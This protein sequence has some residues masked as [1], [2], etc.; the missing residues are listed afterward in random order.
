ML[1]AAGLAAG[2]SSMGNHSDASTAMTLDQLPPAAQQTVRNEVGD[3]QIYSI[4]Q[5]DKDGQTA[6]KVEVQR[7]G[8]SLMKPTLVVAQDGSIIKESRDLADRRAKVNEAAGAQNNSSWDQNGA[9]NSGNSPSASPGSTQAP[10]EANPAG[11][12]PNQAL[13]STSGTSQPQ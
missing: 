10:S 4:K 6:Y 9:A 8:F 7:N 12:N 1:A 5:C 3:T 13:P 2:C 11:S